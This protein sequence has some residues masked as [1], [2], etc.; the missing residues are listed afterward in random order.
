[1]QQMDAQLNEIIKLYHDGLSFA[2]IGRKLRQSRSTIKR[3][4]NKAGIVE[5]N[6]TRRYLLN[7]GDITDIATEIG[8]YW[9]GY[10]SVSGYI[11]HNRYRLNCKVRMQDIGHLFAFCTDVGTTQI[12][13]KHIQNLKDGTTR[14]SAV[15]QLNSKILCEFYQRD[16]QHTRHSVRG[17]WD[18]RG[19]IFIR[20]GSLRLGYTN[21]PNFVNEWCTNNGFIL[22][23]GMLPA[24]QSM[25][26]ARLLY[27]NQSRALQ[28]YINL[29]MTNYQ[30]KK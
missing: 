8:Q 15:L 5:I 28:R 23:N 21:P 6:P 19:R 30:I 11:V 29:V 13:H 20:H 14:S 4:L 22:L 18:A 12:P 1:M 9:F 24:S 27:T 2:A 16:H 25:D 26:L 10:M 17:A 3:R 7:L